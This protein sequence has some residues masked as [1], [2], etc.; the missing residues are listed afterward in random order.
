MRVNSD[1]TLR[2]AIALRRESGSSWLQLS[3]QAR[4]Q[5]F[6]R[7]FFSGGTIERE[8]APNPSR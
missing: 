8:E 5:R 7:A 3:R 1:E 4:H 2:R 6:S